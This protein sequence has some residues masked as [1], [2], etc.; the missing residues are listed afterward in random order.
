[1]VLVRVRCDDR[2]ARTGVLPPA[3]T[4][5]AESESSLSD[6][7]ELMDERVLSELALR[8]L[9]IEVAYDAAWAVEERL[10]SRRSVEVDDKLGSMGATVVEIIALLLDAVGLPISSSLSGTSNSIS[11]SEMTIGSSRV[12]LFVGDDVRTEVSWRLCGSV[13]FEELAET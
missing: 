1:M 8:S 11:L 13:D 9:V 12:L 2:E 3:S 4:C 6:S 5:V 7:S 10:S